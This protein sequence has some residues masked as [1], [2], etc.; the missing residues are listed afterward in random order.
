[1]IPVIDISRVIGWGKT[2]A[3]DVI[4]WIALKALLIALI[5]TVLPLSIY[6][7]WMLIQSQVMIYVNDNMST[8]GGFESVTFQL[9]GLGAWLA[10]CLQFPACLSV[11]MSG[12]AV[13]FV[14]GFFKK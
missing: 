1:M 6:A 10:T 3:A 5:T 2:A 7:G 14:L 12:S 4:K 9:V 11:V 13:K 8:A